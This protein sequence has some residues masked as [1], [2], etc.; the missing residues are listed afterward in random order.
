MSSLLILEKIME[1]ICGAERL[2]HVPRSCDRF[3]FIGGISIGGI[4][5]IMLGWLGMT[6]DECI[7]A[8]KNVAR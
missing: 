2:D 8:Y 6:V 3:D 1:Q 7:R 5:A 4:I